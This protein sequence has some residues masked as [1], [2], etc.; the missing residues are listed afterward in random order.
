[1]E[2]AG[3]RALLAPVAPEV[4]FPAD[5]MVSLTMVEAGVGMEVVEAMAV[6]TVSPRSRVDRRR[7]IGAGRRRTEV[8]RRLIAEEDS[9][10][11]ILTV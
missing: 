6:V 3:P 7:L 8:V 9:V 2:V 10:K 1:M 5:G 11:V 4:P